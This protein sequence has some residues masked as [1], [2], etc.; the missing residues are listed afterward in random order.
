MREK[1]VILWVL[2]VLCIA[3]LLSVGIERLIAR[4]GVRS[5]NQSPGGIALLAE[6]I[7]RWSEERLRK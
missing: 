7:E 3:V 4:L 2:L 6:R 1:Y 5:E